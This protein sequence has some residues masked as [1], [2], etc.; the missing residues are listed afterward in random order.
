LRSRFELGN[1]RHPYLFLRSSVQPATLVDKMG[2]WL[3]AT[4]QGMWPRQLPL[5]E[6]TKCIGWLLYSAPEYDLEELRRLLKRLTGVDVALR[7]RCI[8]DSR[9]A[10]ATQTPSTKAIHIE[11]DK[12]IPALQ[13]TGHERTYSVTARTFPLGIK[14]RLVPDLQTL[15]NLDAYDKAIWLQSIQA[16]F[17]ERTKTHW[18][19]DNVSHSHNSPLPLYDT[20]RAMKLSHWMAAKSAQPLFHAISP[21]ATKDG[22]LVRYLPQYATQAHAAIAKL[23]HQV[24]RMPIA[25]AVTIT[26]TT[27]LQPHSSSKGATTTSS[28]QDALDRLFEI[29]F[30]EPG[31]VHLRPIPQPCITGAHHNI[32]TRAPS[33]SSYQLYNW[34]LAL[35]QLFQNT[36]WDRWR[37]RNGIT[38]PLWDSVS[39]TSGN[40]NHSQP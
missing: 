33:P 10:K 11:V 1:T 39:P 3:R 25:P 13:L 16:K 18:I 6:Q 23:S 31:Y 17:L 29:R 5:V 32:H 7:F 28:L 35:W 4:K 15:T 30:T 9:P 21:M 34:L 2:P 20:L 8:Q 36:A 24:P 22:Y 14:M 27:T 40:D 12:S 26:T 38:Q 19:R 37:Y